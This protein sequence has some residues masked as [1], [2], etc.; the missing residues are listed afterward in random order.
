MEKIN[1]RKLFESKIDEIDQAFQ[2]L[3]EAIKKDS[4][5]SGVIFEAIKGSFLFGGN[6]DKSTELANLYI[7][8]IQKDFSNMDSEKKERCEDLVRCIKF[9]IEGRYLPFL[10]KEKRDIA[11]AYSKE[12]SSL[13]PFLKHLNPYIDSKDND[14]CV[15]CVICK[16][17]DKEC[18]VR[19]SGNN[20]K[21]ID[22]DVVEIETTYMNTVY[23]HTF[24]S[25]KIDH[26][27]HIIMISLFYCILKLTF[28][29][30]HNKIR[31]IIQDHQK[32]RPIQIMNRALMIQYFE[33]VCDDTLEEPEEESLFGDMCNEDS[34]NESIKEE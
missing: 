30:K 26:V 10:N 14:N 8:E 33:L 15:L 6:P 1:I 20:D 16:I 4:L 5:K 25:E 9:V 3:E 34:D 21:L 27:G 31:C 13:S 28:D 23:K 19:F 22:S 17:N 11:M 29:A 2:T 32:H 12:K 18:T 24:N 7:E